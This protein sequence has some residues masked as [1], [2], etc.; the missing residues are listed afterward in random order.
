MEDNKTLYNVEIAG[1]PLKLRSS[2]D[3]ATV[4]ELV[5]LVDDKVDEALKINQGISFQNAILLAALHI[6]EEL[7]LTRRMAQLEIGGLQ[8]QAQQILSDLD[9]SPLTQI[10]L[11]C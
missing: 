5:S 7:I 8:D 3:D 2:H 10:R 6:A 11:N 4:E 1:L 9:A